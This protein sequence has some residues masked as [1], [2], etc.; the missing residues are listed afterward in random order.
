MDGALPPGMDLNHGAACIY[1]AYADKAYRTGMNRSTDDPNPHVLDVV[2]ALHELA[3]RASPFGPPSDSIILGPEFGGSEYDIRADADLIADGTAWNIKAAVSPV[4]S[5]RGQHAMLWPSVK[6]GIALVLLDW[7]NDYDLKH[8]GIYWGRH[9]AATV[10]SLDEIAVLGWRPIPELRERLRDWLAG[11]WQTEA[12]GEDAKQAG[13]FWWSLQSGDLARGV[14]PGLARAMSGALALEDTPE[15]HLEALAVA[16]AVPLVAEP[17]AEHLV[18]AVLAIANADLE[19]TEQGLTQ[20]AKD[21][22]YYAYLIRLEALESAAYDARRALRELER[23]D[24]KWVAAAVAAA[25]AE[26]ERMYRYS[27][28][29]SAR[30]PVAE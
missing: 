16:R 23:G 14:A 27:S 21:F 5:A 28:L 11:G 19:R 9:G 20:S 24:A 22:L 17:M 13:R 12:R 4:A 26:T 30:R 18:R 8:A 29:L 6:E 7:N 15:G 2:D 25:E 1:L 3:K 10:L